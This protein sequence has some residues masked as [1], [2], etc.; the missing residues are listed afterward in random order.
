MVTMADVASAAGVSRSTV[1]LVLNGRHES[2][3]LA[4]DTVARVRAVAESLGYR[5]NELARAMITGRNPFLCLLTPVVADELSSRCL[6]AAVAE[7]ERHGQYLHVLASGQDD[8]ACAAAVERCIELRPAGVVA[9]N[10]PAKVQAKLSTELD[11]YEIPLCAMQPFH[12]GQPLAPALDHLFDLGHRRVG[13]VSIPSEPALEASFLEAM[14]ASWQAVPA[15][16]LIRTEEG[17]SDL[18]DALR[19]VL[20][21]RKTRPTALV[22]TS[23]AAALMVL[24]AA[25]RLDLKV[26]KELSVVGW[27]NLALGALADP[28]LTTVEPPITDL[29]GQAVAR[30][31]GQPPV[32]NAASAPRIVVR[33]STAAAS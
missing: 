6:A 22:C 15:E 13:L 28:P 26:P 8:A 18:R 21:S 19:E 16:H 20:R 14:K 10:L 32:V 2:V 4:A 7:A 31:L 12:G 3:G 9:W 1:S 25:R 29:A 27:G 11:R 33:K 17:E 24:R 30:L 5:K 23:D